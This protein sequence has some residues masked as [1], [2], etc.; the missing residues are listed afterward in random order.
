MNYLSRIVPV[1]FALL[2]LSAAAGEVFSIPSD[3]L[4]VLISIPPKTL[5]PTR[6]DGETIQ[7]YSRLYA[8]KNNAENVCLSHKALLVKYA[9]GLCKD[10]VPEAKITGVDSVG[11]PTRISQ[12]GI[13]DEWRP[14][15]SQRYT[16]RYCLSRV[17]CEK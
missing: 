4:F 7:I 11:A 1:I 17:V 15:K 13:A 3:E 10:L 16:T 14:E 8:E 12:D 6:E 9:T 2:S 5:Y